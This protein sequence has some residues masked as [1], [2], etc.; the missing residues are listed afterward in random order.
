M[1]DRRQ[2]AEI[3]RADVVVYNAFLGTFFPFFR[4]L[5]N[6]TAIACFRLFTLPPLPLFA[7]P[8]L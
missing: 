7:V 5:D 8:R 6:P 4:A 3:V 1:K 2:A